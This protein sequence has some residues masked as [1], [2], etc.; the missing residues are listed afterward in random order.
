ENTLA[1][2]YDNIIRI[3]L[4]QVDR[5]SLVVHFC[6][7]EENLLYLIQ[8][9]ATWGH[10]IINI[11]SSYLNDP[12]NSLFVPI[13]VEKLDVE[14]SH[15]DTVAFHHR[16]ICGVSPILDVR[17]A[18][19]EDDPADNQIRSSHQIVYSIILGIT[20][21]EDGLGPRS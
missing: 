18:G 9:R 3:V 17:C 13:R 11:E 5:V 4:D 8:A 20:R 15:R 1:P 16:I 14:E 7:V 12:C 21:P 6:Q 19:V 2:T 10:G